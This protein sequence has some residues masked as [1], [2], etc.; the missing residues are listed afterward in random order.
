MNE[1]KLKKMYAGNNLTLNYPRI[2][3]EAGFKSTTL[4]QITAEHKNKE[5][6]QYDCVALM[7]PDLAKV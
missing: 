6:N 2:V 5:K 1:Y 3:V 7:V 4:A